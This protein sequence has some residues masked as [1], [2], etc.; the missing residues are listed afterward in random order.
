[1]PAGVLAAVADDEA[2]DRKQ[3]AA[4]PADVS[5]EQQPAA[6]VAA[7]VT[8]ATINFVDLAGS[9][10][11]SQVAES[12]EKEKLRQKEV[13]CIQQSC[14]AKGAACLPAAG[15]VPAYGAVAH[16]APAAAKQSANVA[17]F[18][19][20]DC[21]T[22]F[23]PLQAGNINKSLLTLSSV[24]RALADNPVSIITPQL[25][26]IQYST[27]IQVQAMPVYTPHA[28]IHT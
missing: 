23:L 4:A 15:M 25:H 6:A 14:Q 12:S 22:T 17:A 2:V 27:A 20:H 24:I 9:E 19:L 3:D 16:A 28:C 10:R 7:A 11:G 8:T 26:C 1:M 18:V 13:S 5:S 21:T